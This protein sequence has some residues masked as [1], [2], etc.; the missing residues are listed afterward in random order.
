MSNDPFANKGQLGHRDPFAST[1]TKKTNTRRSDS[2]VESIR[3]I[4]S[5]TLKSLT[6][7]VVKGTAQTVFDQILGSARTGQAP[8]AS[9][10]PN[11]YEDW[12]KDRENSAAEQART[13]ERAFQHHRQSEQQVVFSMADEKVKQEMQGIRQEL[14][15]LTKSMG[16]VQAQI[17]N[18]V[19]DNIVDP[20][21]YHLNYFRKLKEWI[22]LMRKSLDD[23]SGWLSMSNGRKG[24]G[25]YWTQTAKSGTKYSMSQERQVQ[26]GA[27]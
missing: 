7:D 8:D 3:D 20:G 27:G 4:G 11:F 21:V 10:V 14:A 15:M 17:E 9:S 1:S 26:M 16:Q 2:F 13:Q 25:Y 12:V 5:S 23:A 19:M 24:K 18:A 6:N 22:V